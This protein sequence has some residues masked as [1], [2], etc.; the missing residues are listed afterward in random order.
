M[1]RI[2]VV[3][4][5]YNVERYLDASLASLA[6]QSV[7]DLEVLMVNDGSTDASR[8]I[9]AEYAQRD[10][11][12]RLIDRPNGGLSAARNT[13]L[14]AAGGEFLAF[15][16]SDDVLPPNAYELL[17]G[18]LERSGSAFASGNVLRLRG[19]E[20]FQARFLAT[21]F[22]RTQVA[23]H[24]TRFRPLIADRIVW[25]KL[26]RRSFWDDQGYRFPEGRVHEDI[27]IVVPAQFSARS[28]DVI[29]DPVYHW[30]IRESGELSITQRRLEQRVLLDRLTALEEVRAHLER[31]G[32]RRGRRWYDESVVAD[33][34]RLHLNVL[35]SAD[36]AYR[37]LFMERVNAFLDGASPRIYD[38]L[39]AI[40]RLKWHLVRHRRLDELLEVLRFQEEDL[41]GTPP[42]RLGRHWYGD[43]PFREDPRLRIPRSVYRLRS[44][45]LPGVAHLDSLRSED[46]ALVIRGF[47]YVTGIGAP[48]PG[49]QRVGLSVLP[50]G[51]LRRVRLRLT[52]VRL[53]TRSVERA[54]ATARSEQELTDLSWSGFEATV[55]PRRL[56]RRGRGREGRW[57]L[58]VTVSAGG[59]RRRRARFVID[60][61]RPARPAE[62]P[63]GDA[64]VLRA[65]PTPAAGVDLHLHRAWATVTGAAAADEGVELAITSSGALD[66]GELR[67]RRE[68]DAVTRSVPVRAEGGALRAVIAPGEL[69]AP[70]GAAS[71]PSPWRL[72]LRSGGRT[73]PVLIEPALDGAALRAGERALALVRT[74][75]G[76]AGVVERDPRPVAEAARFDGSRLTLSGTLPAGEELLV[77]GPDAGAAHAFG[78][79]A[80]DGRFTV[81]LDPAAIDGVLPLGEGTWRL[82]VRTGHDLVP[83]AAARGLL[84]SFPL[85]GAGAR[86]RFAL[87]AN[88]DLALDV[89][90]DL[91]DDERGAFHQRRLRRAHYRREQPLREAVVYSSFG[92]R[93]CSDSP[94]AIHTE[95]VRRGAP[96]EHLWVVRDGAFAT[97]AN[98]TPLRKGAPEYFEALASARY[99]VTNDRL[100]PWFRS[101]SDQVCV[102]TLH[103]APLR[104]LGFDVVENR[105]AAKRLLH[106]LD[107]EVA[108][109]THLVSPAPYATPLLQSAYG[110]ED[111]VLETGAPRCDVLA[112]PEL[113]AKVRARL[114]LR[115][116]TRAVLYA[117]TFR[118]DA[119]DRRG[120]YR[121]DLRL[122]LD[123][124]RQA[125]GA[126]AVVLFRKHPA[127]SEGPPG[128]EPWRVRNVSGYPDATELLAAVDVLITDY[129]SLMVDFAN[130]G[131]PILCFADDLDSYR[132]EVRGFYFDFE[133]TVPAPVLRTSDALHDA[134]RDPEAH[135]DRHAERYSA[136]TQRFCALDDGRAAA[137]VA[138]RVF[139]A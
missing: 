19:T 69:A 124:L 7:G 70:E 1:P 9:A 139:A 94:R 55:P 126:D 18:A 138:D 131:R 43:Y 90:R 28:V 135:R 34:L 58:Y 13:G 122:D 77:A 134:L 3:V 61:A 15:L 109:W 91:A 21:T 78:L 82:Y 33:D 32:P 60:P 65:V 73:L 88:P 100:P 81:A 10:P 133:A 39:P 51:R 95:L 20:T 120:R 16:D 14:D 46:G 104:R 112:D 119:A 47:A 80:G 68:S 72:S 66:G 74:D 64:A 108:N 106:G 59:V 8:A 113:R 111:Q 132:E 26:W 48:Q 24:V 116:G 128:P 89:E 4:P 30:R 11:R 92:G 36:D 2:S 84:D 37:E 52:P 56:L 87:T 12:F 103:G 27:P 5:I 45:D 79:D 17:L 118:E 31:N 22:A 40:D 130:T 101:R 76:L 53:R 121:L 50:P 137:R 127:I 99:L 85:T 57:E 44:A 25:N 63:A 67:L 62:L 42:V 49:S 136:F 93:Q 83:L 71:P 98:A 115:E 129:S 117:P 41:P 114:G 35:D 23:T 97:P 96:L 75:A 86:K 107:D 6:R 110:V 38:G 54:D 102:Q 125:A 123:W 29:A 105:G